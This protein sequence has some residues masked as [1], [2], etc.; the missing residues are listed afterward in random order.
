MDQ[1]AKLKR[2][3]LESRRKASPEP[4]IHD[5][6]GL[7]ALRSFCR[8]NYLDYARMVF[9]V[10]ST[11]LFI[12][13]G[14]YSLIRSFNKLDWIVRALSYGWLATIGFWLW[15]I[16]RAYR[17]ERRRLMVLERTEF[18]DVRE[19][20]KSLDRAEFAADYIPA[21]RRALA[22]AV[23][24][25]DDALDRAKW[26]RLSVPDAKERLAQLFV[27]LQPHLPTILSLRRGESETLGAF[28]VRSELWK[29]TPRLELNLQKLHNDL[30]RWADPTSSP[31]WP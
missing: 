1:V 6:G 15:V 22:D 23:R 28:R 5:I 27:T 7:S 2:Q 20:V 25:L 12:S 8:I 9:E 18:A 13:V 21:A 24:P 30:A 4:V 31:A 29:S 26:N 17:S 16:V 3:L 10:A 11:T 19:F 14:V